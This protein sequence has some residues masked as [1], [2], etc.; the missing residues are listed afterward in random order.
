MLAAAFLSSLLG[1]AAPPALA[2]RRPKVSAKAAIV[3]DGTT[4]QILYAKN[5]HE[6]LP[7]ASTTKMMAATVAL[8]HGRLSDIV[9]V[10]KKAADTGGS[11]MYLEPGEKLTFKQLLYGML[12]VSGNDATEAVAEYIS[13][14]P[15][16][17]VALMNQKAQELGLHDTHYVTPHGLPAA[18]H[19]SS[20]YDLAMIARYAFKNPVFAKITDT[21]VKVLPGNDRI[22]HRILVNHNR[23]LRYFPGALGG[24]T[25]YTI[26]AG[27]CFVG[28]AE[29]NGRFVIE[30]ILNDRACWVDAANLLNYGLDDFKSEPIAAAGQVIASVPV[31]GGTQASEH[32]VLQDAV[33]LSVRRGGRRP[34]V[35]ATFHMIPELTAPVQSGEI[36]GRYQLREGDRLIAEAPLVAA[37]SIPVAPPV[38]GQVGAAFAWFLKGGALSVALFS[39]FRLRGLRRRSRRQ[40]VRKTYKAVG[41]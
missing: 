32:A 16:K 38:W 22:P 35:Q 10:S 19:Y 11:S 28:S 6:H 25:G 37:D 17:F 36:L 41:L 31:K 23:L 7:M 24:K 33:D 29:R 14:D 5:I 9:E 13:G 26:A 3:I 30:A 34:D 4:G 1:L 39:V 27:K 12:L 21:R 18:G 20:A 8:E 2:F 40:R 15:K